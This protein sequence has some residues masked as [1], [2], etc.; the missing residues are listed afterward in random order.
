[1]TRTLAIIA[2]LSLPVQAKDM[3]RV[4]Q[5]GGDAQTVGMAWVCRAENVTFK[6]DKKRN[7]TTVRFRHNGCAIVAIVPNPTPTVEWGAIKTVALAIVCSLVP[8]EMEEC[9]G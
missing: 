1:M 7:T 8:T 2:A 6:R 3:S 4:P 9:N 5:T